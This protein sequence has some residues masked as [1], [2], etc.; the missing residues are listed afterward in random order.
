ME[1][2]LAPHKDTKPR[3]GQ[4][5]VNW[6]LLVITLGVLAVTGTAGY[7]WH[8][9]QE[10]SIGQ[11]LLDR[12]QK[13]EDEE[14]FRGAS[15]YLHR[16]LAL[17]PADKSARVRLAK[18]YDKAAQS[19]AAYARAVELYY[20]ALGNADPDETNP[21]RARTVELLLKTSRFSEAFEEALKLVAAYPQYLE[22]ESIQA[23]VTAGTPSPEAADVWRQLATARYA[24][25]KSGILDSPGTDSNNS[26]TQSIASLSLEETLEAAILINPANLDL[27]IMLAEVFREHPDQLRDPR[28]SAANRAN[29]ANEL[30]DQMVL[31]NPKNAHA[32]MRRARYRMHYGESD[33]EADVIRSLEL[34]K[35]DVD[36]V[37]FA[38]RYY[39]DRGQN[40]QSKGDDASA[41]FN[42][43]LAQYLAIIDELDKQ[44]LA[45]HVEAG[46]VH[47]AMG[48]GEQ[49][50]ELW[51]EALVTCELADASTGVRQSVGA[52]ADTTRQLF[53]K[54]TENYIATGRLEEAR[55]SLRR[56][57]NSLA[58]LERIGG[59]NLVWKHVR[60]LLQ[61]RLALAEGD[62]NG[63]L[64]IAQTIVN[65]PKT[66]KDNLLPAWSLKARAHNT[67]AQWDLA[68]GAYEALI[69][70]G[71]TEA[72][73]RLAAA[74]AWRLA[75]VP[76]KTIEHLTDLDTARSNPEILY[77]LAR[78]RLQYQLRLAPTKRNWSKL[79]SNLAALR[80]DDFQ[81]QLAQPWRVALLHAA[82]A[83]AR[84]QLGGYDTP[85]GE[86]PVELLNAVEQT[87]PDEAPLIRELVLRYERLGQPQAADRALAK[88]RELTDSAGN[89]FLAAQ[90]YIRRKQF[91]LARESIAAA[92]PKL[93]EEQAPGA[94]LALARV[95]LAAGKMEAAERRLAALAKNTSNPQ[96]TRQL[97][98]L[99]IQIG[100]STLTEFEQELVAAEG[101]D[102]TQW[103]LVKAQQILTAAAKTKDLATRERLIREAEDLQIAIDRRRPNWSKTYFLKALVE[104]AK[105][106]YPQAVSDYQRAIELGE[107]SFMTF[108]RLVE[109]LNNLGRVVEANNYLSVLKDSIPNHD[110][111]SALAINIAAKLDNLEQAEAYAL[112]R[113]EANPEDPRALMW[114]G[115]VL[116]MSNQLEAAQQQFEK[117]TQIAPEDVTTWTSLFRF[118]VFAKQRDAAEA[119]L[120]K[121]AQAAESKGP[122]HRAFMLARGHETLENLAA[123]KQ[124]YL[125]A[126]QESP[127]EIAFQQGLTEF[128]VKHRQDGS[129]TALRKLLALTRGKPS[130]RNLFDNTRRMLATALARR[131]KAGDFEEA[132]RLLAAGGDDRR[133]ASLD[134]RLQAVI[135]TQ[136]GQPKLEA[137]QNVLEEL[138]AEGDANVGDHL[139]LG[140][141]Y[142][143]Q[144]KQLRSNASQ[145]EDEETIARRIQDAR[146]QFETACR[147]NDAL[148]SH[149]VVY[150]RALLEL[151]AWEPAAEWIDRFQERFPYDIQWVTA[152]IRLLKARGQTNSIADAI[153]EYD[154]GLASAKLPPA[155]KAIALAKLGQLFTQ[156][157]F[158][159]QAERCHTEANEIDSSYFPDL[160]LARVN[161]AME[162]A[163][164]KE[165]VDEA[166]KTALDYASKSK[167]PR[168]T[169]LLLSALIKAKQTSQT[170]PGA[171]AVVKKALRDFPLDSILLVE[172]GNLRIVEHRI[173]EA[174][175]LYRRAIQINE[176]NVI[177]LNNLST[178]L[179]EN[180]EKDKRQQALP[181]I[182]KA[183]QLAGNRP[184]LLDTKGM[185]LFHLH[186]Y[187]AAVKLLRQAVD[188]KNSDPRHTFH[189]AA[190][191][192]RAGNTHDA[193][194]AYLS[195]KRQK[196]QDAFLTGVDRQLQKELEQL[197]SQGESTTQASK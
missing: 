40:L 142:Y 136:Q 130:Q 60:D 97:A 116:R 171:D 90:L 32:L 73:I 183:I 46:Q 54:L 182:D 57:N 89:D 7:F 94:E 27:P 174:I 110:N 62:G 178:L 103:R 20:Q 141:V 4:R 114:Y 96:L 37:L 196:L 5:E 36:I 43:S 69:R 188:V 47:L 109:L 107:S 152:K 186:D 120:Q 1:S 115:D 99:Q 67:L 180:P 91:D 108:Q 111:L 124:E 88:C 102:G 92:K 55:K 15:R 49:G 98:D 161:S 19:P 118:H 13:L 66:R 187:H 76:H 34:A 121:A 175:A 3:R 28:L 162:N 158:H 154:Q 179:A 50:I 104:D 79:A 105:G 12:I 157:E 51:E 137:A 18:D 42:K 44:H 160:I 144:S 138:V 95:D 52:R 140:W 113:V 23:A 100:K 87:Y 172:V 117:A 41:D 9:R 70:L 143:M 22:L 48:N 184:A 135:Y 56:L 129:E 86:S 64:Q 11:T 197:I 35:E 82:F 159:Q 8:L 84:A 150:I 80:Q 190:A 192:K 119:T 166:L 61:G 181:L 139:L 21:L 74:E 133:I 148:P 169:S 6:R 26:D 81:T 156:H 147:Q 177:A 78:S 14:D 17:Q 125:Q 58:Q 134:K 63:A 53:T 29:R 191:L 24:K 72:D 30:A 122:G 101:Q 45:A 2:L 131:G 85:N 106:N 77:Q 83:E 132:K 93:T 75:G 173:D 185:V 189:L 33:I 39:H 170:F 31:R 16:Y 145:P 68:A 123:A 193:K 163:S 151:E 149:F 59:L 195:A 112:Q 127:E 176:N 167:S 164:D 146:E 194:L 165:Q 155:Q 10:K 168:A 128:L 153:N 38:A 25:I 65:D 126:T 71:A